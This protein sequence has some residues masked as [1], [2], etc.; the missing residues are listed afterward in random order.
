MIASDIRVGSGG[1][2]IMWPTMFSHIH[3]E[4]VTFPC[5][6]CE[7]PVAAVLVMP[8]DKRKLKLLGR[9]TR[10]FKAGDKQTVWGELRCTKGEWESFVMVDDLP[11]LK[12]K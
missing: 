6:D 8:T 11:V 12:E 4:S 5:P 10:C 3:S 7:S 2:V 9:C 1:A